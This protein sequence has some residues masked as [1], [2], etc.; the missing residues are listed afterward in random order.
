[1]V[2][3]NPGFLTQIAAEYLQHAGQNGADGSDGSIDVISRGINILQKVV[4]KSPGFLRVQLTLASA[5][6]ANNHL[7]EASKICNMVCCF[8][9]NIK[10]LNCP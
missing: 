6:L 5:R 9:E 10:V 3:L 4:N 8:N 1:M 2:K 7:D